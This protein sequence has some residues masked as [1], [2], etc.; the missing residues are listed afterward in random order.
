MTPCPSTMTTPSGMASMKS[1]ARPCPCTNRDYDRSGK[2]VVEARPSPGHVGRHLGPT[3]QSQLHEHV[4]HVVLDR[5][6][7]QVDGLGDLAVGQALGHEVE[8]L[9]LLAG[10]V[11]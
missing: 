2:A 5:F 4:G 6:L 9:Q 11:G 3:G 1:A 7:G 8:N 10:Q